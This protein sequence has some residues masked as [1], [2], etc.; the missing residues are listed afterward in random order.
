[1]GPVRARLAEGPRARCGKQSGRRRVR[2][3]HG[4]G[5]R[6]QR[7]ARR[8]ADG[9]ERLCRDALGDRRRARHACRHRHAPGVRQRRVHGHV[10]RRRVRHQGRLRRRP[11]DVE[12]RRRHPATRRQHI[13]CRR[14]AHHDGSRHVAE[15]R[16]FDRH[17][18]RH[19]PRHRGRPGPSADQ[20]VQRRRRCRRAPRGP[21]AAAETRSRSGHLAAGRV[22]GRARHHHTDGAR[23]SLHL[24][25]ALTRRR[26][27][28]DRDAG[29]PRRF[30][31]RHG[32]VG[33]RLED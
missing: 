8:R 24:H 33:G 18:R 21:D 32:A 5:E 26:R 27:A 31:S 9:R 4:V 12:R 22:A 15:R 14:L 29:Q 16:S 25:A 17:D 19:W 11:A 30:G 10:G 20:R 28:V 2:Q 7:A 13:Q 1:M 6:R 3:V 23:R